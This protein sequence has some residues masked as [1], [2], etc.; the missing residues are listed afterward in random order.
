MTDSTY[1]LVILGGGLAGL[2]L[3][4]ALADRNYPGSVLIL[5]GRQAYAD[6]RSWCFWARDGS[7]VGR[8]ATVRWPKWALGEAGADRI[9][10]EAPGWHYAYCR[11]SDVY[12]RRLAKIES[13]PRTHLR[14]NTTVDGVSGRPGDYRIAVGHE[15]I[16]AKRAVDCRS[17]PPRAEPILWQE[18]VGIELEVDHGLDPDT[19]EVMADIRATDSGIAFTYL[20]PLSPT[21]V[22]V[23]ATRFSREKLGWDVL[24]SDLDAALGERGLIG[25]RILRTEK[26]A[27]PMGLPRSGGRAASVVP[28]AGNGGG[29]LRAA[30]GYAFLRIGA[31]AQSAADTLS[32]G[33]P[34]RGHPKERLSRFLIDEAFLRAVAGNPAAAP[35]F[36]T[37]MA[38]RVPP[39]TFAAFMI[40]EAL[41]P[42]ALVR[43]LP[44]LPMLAAAARTARSCR[45]A[46]L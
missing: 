26:G 22:L 16:V 43:S 39:E 28:R 23:E 9:V 38:K 15:E 3:A 17:G 10:R 7:A 32:A 33:G 12:A 18:F 44:K 34:I 5:E 37:A 19:A 45:W 2:S 14:L 21:S 1:D 41:L 27:L 40:D 31:W 4:A 11:S 29:A 8:D 46:S 13:A 24:R 30:S 6:D 36:F 20:L 42:P 25:G 35:A